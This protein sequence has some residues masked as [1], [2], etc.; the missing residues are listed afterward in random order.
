MSPPSR[1]ESHSSLVYLG[2]DKGVGVRHC[3]EIKHPF[4]IRKRVL[5]FLPVLMPVTPVAIAVWVK[6]APVSSATA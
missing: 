3:V 4:S 1:F 5:I 2:G 6:M